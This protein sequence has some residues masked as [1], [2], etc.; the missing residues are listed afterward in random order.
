[1]I[2]LKLKLRGIAPL[3]MQSAVLANPL[4][5]MTKEI[6]E[7]TG[8][9]TKT[10]DDQEHLLK[11]KFLASFYW[12]AK[13]GPYIPG[14]N[15]DRAYFDAAKEMKKGKKFTQYAMI[16]ENKL[17]L[18]YD[19][20][21][22]PEE[23]YA[24]LNFVDVRPVKIRASRIQMCRPIFK[25]W[26]L[27]A[28]LAFNEQLMDERLIRQISSFVGRQGLGTFRRRFGKFEVAIT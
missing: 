1:M 20:P 10:D 13:V 28:T 16:V 11:L 14:Q 4:H 24:N 7:F 19:G 9:A 6:K 17:P 3:I 12:D 8:L 26:S 27:D 2:E 5:P 23:L 21:R 25:V 22:T 15:L 18:I